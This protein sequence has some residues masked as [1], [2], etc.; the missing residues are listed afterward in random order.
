MSWTYEI[1]TGLLYEPQGNALEPPGYAGHGEGLNNP[2]MCNVEDV[3]PLPCGWYTVGEPISDPHVGEFALPLTPDPLNA[4]FGRA[5]FYC[6]GDSIAHPGGHL[7]S[8]GCIVQ[9]KPNRVS[10]ATSTDKRLQVV[11]RLN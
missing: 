1:V 4:M 9:P 3:G 10:L 5:D 6:H 8:D 11:A 7:A 2:L